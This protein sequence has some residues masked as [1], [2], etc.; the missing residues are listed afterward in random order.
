M[1]VAEKIFKVMGSK[2]IGMQRRPW[3]YYELER[4]WT[5]DGI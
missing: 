2:V 1:G 5:A 3:K 4:S